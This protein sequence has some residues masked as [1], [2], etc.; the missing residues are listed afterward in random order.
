VI[1]HRSDF[2]RQPHRSDMS[3]RAQQPERSRSA[4]PDFVAETARARAQCHA[5]VYQLPVRAVEPTIL[6]RDKVP[7]SGAA[8]NLNPAETLHMN[9][10]ECETQHGT[11]PGHVN[12]PGHWYAKTGSNEVMSNNST[13]SMRATLHW[14]RFRAFCRHFRRHSAGRR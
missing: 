5:F 10:G 7:T 12:R 8:Q 1:K 14:S 9:A 13:S 2:V 11:S 4:R 3:R 6:Q